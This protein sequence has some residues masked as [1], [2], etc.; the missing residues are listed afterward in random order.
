MLPRTGLG[1][2]PF[3]AH[4]QGQQ[5]LPQGVVDLV[6][7]GVVQVFPLEPDAGATVGSA[8]VGGET[9]G[10]IQR[11]RP[12]DVVL[13]QTV[14]LGGESGI[15]PGLGR[16]LLQFRQGRHQG[17]G[18]VLATE[19]SKAAMGTG[20]HRWLQAGG[21]RSAG[22]RQGAGHGSKAERR[23]SVSRRSR[24]GAPHRRSSTMQAGCDRWMPKGGWQEFSSA[25]SCSDR[26]ALRRS[27]QP[28]RSKWC[29]CSPPV[30]AKGAKP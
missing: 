4:S 25:E 19:S 13:E 2:D 22:V 20:A 17:L 12:A 18:H 29:G 3:L 11:C 30:V 24:H 8:V 14:E 16:C 9:L 10:L 6:G 23:L 28:R 26:A 21:I 27:P 1:N 7:T 15:V 5:G